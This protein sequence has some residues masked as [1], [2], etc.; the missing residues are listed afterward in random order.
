MPFGTVDGQ[1]VIAVT[2]VFLN[3]FILVEFAPQLIKIS[4]FQF[5]AVPD[6]TA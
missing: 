4:D 2:D 1:H 6:L 3:G 5:Y